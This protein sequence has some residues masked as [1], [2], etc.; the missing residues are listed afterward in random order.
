MSIRDNSSASGALSETILYFGK[1]Y[2]LDVLKVFCSKSSRVLN[3]F[4]VL[5]LY[6][7]KNNEQK[8]SLLSFNFDSEMK[9]ERFY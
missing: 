7:S 5:S 9:V 3:S 4:T 2:F 6:S 1:I 8:G